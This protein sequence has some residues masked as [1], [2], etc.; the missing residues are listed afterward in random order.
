MHELSPY[1][2]TKMGDK[3]MDEI[4]GWK[5]DYPSKSKHFWQGDLEKSLRQGTHTVTVRT[6]DMFG[7]TYEGHRVFRIE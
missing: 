3:A 6:T 4:F 7:N 2:D 5:M 1:L